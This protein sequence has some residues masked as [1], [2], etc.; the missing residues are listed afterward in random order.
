MSTRCTINF[1]YGRPTDIAAKIYRHSDGYPG[2]VDGT[3][4]GVLADLQTFFK[5]VKE[6]TNDTRFM[7][8]TYLAAKFVVWQ[9]GEF[10]RSGKPL[11]F[12]SLGVCQKDPGDIAYTYFVNCDKMDENGCPTVTYRAV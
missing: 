1:T 10:S 12:L 5:T 2:T 8:P 3:E 6:Q 9:A 4:Y 11:D 7:D